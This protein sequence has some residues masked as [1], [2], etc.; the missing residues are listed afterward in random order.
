MGAGNIKVRKKIRLN[1]RFK[2]FQRHSLIIVK[3]IPTGIIKFKIL[4]GTRSI[5][6][7]LPAF[8]KCINQKISGE[9]FNR[10]A[11][12]SARHSNIFK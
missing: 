10:Y 4:I 7:F 11:I 8:T 12:A 9:K 5:K 3:N 2:I 6:I 1:N